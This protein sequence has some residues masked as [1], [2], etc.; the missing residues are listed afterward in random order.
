MI[1]FDSL[2][3]FLVPMPSKIQ[4]NALQLHFCCSNYSRRIAH[5]PTCG[6]AT[7][8]SRSLRCPSCASVRR[9]AIN[10]TFGIAHIRFTAPLKI[11]ENIKAIVIALDP[12]LVPLQPP[13]PNE[14]KIYNITVPTVRS[15]P[16]SPTSEDDLEHLPTP[17]SY[18]MF[19]S[20]LSRSP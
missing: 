19:L 1:D 11:C 20:E 7:K 14:Q 4:A 12:I 15:R 5:Q 3:Y 6:I 13:N 2:A 17:S 16:F 8:I 18:L 10:R 9:L